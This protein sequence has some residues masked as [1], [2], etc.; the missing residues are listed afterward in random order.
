M[1]FLTAFYVSEMLRFYIYRPTSGFTDAGLQP[2]GL[3]I[4][5]GACP[6]DRSVA[7]GGLYVYG[8]ENGGCI[9]GPVS[10]VNTS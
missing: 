7:D 6:V 2:V 1:T 10:R 9:Q 3:C 4:H 5:T 8:E